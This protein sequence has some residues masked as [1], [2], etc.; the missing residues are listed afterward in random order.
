MVATLELG[1]ATRAHEEHAH[2]RRGDQRAQGD[3]Q[4]VCLPEEEHLPRGARASARKR[5]Q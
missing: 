3:L 4:R 1:V 2:A 5:E